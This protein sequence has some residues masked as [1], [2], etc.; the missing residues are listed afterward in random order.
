MGS[1]RKIR[2]LTGLAVTGASVLV[3]AGCAQ[4]SSPNADDKPV[5]LEYATWGNVD[6]VVKLWND[7]HPDIHVKVTKVPGGQ[8]AYKAFQAG[9]AA[10]NG[11]DV[12][13]ME[14]QQLISFVADDDLV[15]ISEYVSDDADKFVEWTWKS[16]SPGGKT[17]AVPVDAGPVAIAFN[18]AVLDQ[19]GIAIPT[20]WDEYAA[21]AEKLHAADP[22]KVLGSFPPEGSSFSALAW[23]AGA[24]WFDATDDAW[25]VSVNDEASVKVADYWQGMVDKGLVTNEMPFTT[26]LWSRLDSGNIASILC[27]AWMPAILATNLTATSGQWKVVPLPQWKAGESVTGNLGGGSNAVLKGAEHPKQAAEFAEWLGSDPDAV[28]LQIQKV[29]I[30]PAAIAALDDPA[31]DKEDPFFGGQSVNDV[32]K[33]VAQG[34]DTSWTWGPVMGTTITSVGEHLAAAIQNKSS[35]TDALAAAQDD[36]VAAMEKGDFPVAK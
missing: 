34:V 32:F 1:A 27:P 11:P 13:S 2:I 31:L 20:T 26:E 17:Y 7:T 22:T 33:Q 4:P 3:L 19:F 16:V 15:D 24:K 25:T 12:V 9:V 30:F 29:G 6:D 14:Y 8:D 18:T 10:G 35:F 23:Q 36:T 21:A 28:S 5:T